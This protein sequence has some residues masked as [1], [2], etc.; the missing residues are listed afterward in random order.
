VLIFFR[1]FIF[2]FLFSFVVWFVGVKRK[3]MC[4]EKK[5]YEIGCCYMK[6]GEVCKFYSSFY[7]LLFKLLYDLLMIFS[8]AL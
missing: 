5:G 6:K 3:V 1:I 8:L 2:Y 4:S 7:F